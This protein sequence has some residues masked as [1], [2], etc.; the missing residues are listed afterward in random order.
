MS[1]SR[2]QPLPGTV[3]LSHYYVQTF[4]RSLSAK[5]QNKRKRY[6]PGIVLSEF[7]DAAAMRASGG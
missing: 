4:G 3:A 5:L 2:L 7:A 6:H 1:V